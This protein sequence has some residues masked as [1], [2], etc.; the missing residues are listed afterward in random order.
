MPMDKDEINK[1]SLDHAWNWFALHA[2][3][4]MQTF[5][6][7]LIVTGFMVAG[8]SSLLE[9]QNSVA[10][11]VALLGAWVSYWFSRLDS[12]TRQLIKAGEETLKLLQARLATRAK[13][14]EINMLANVERTDLGA[15]S[16]TK[17]IFVIEWS[18]TA[19]FLIAAIYAA[20][21]AFHD[22]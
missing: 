9:N 4:R 8:Y 5:N 12:R 16:Y 18:V 21:L 20:K 17:V 14:Q 19:G 22:Q 13:L 3:Q 15:S 11:G 6:Y 7:F 2:A 10:I 1:I